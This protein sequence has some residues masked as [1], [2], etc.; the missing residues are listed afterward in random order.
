MKCCSMS[1][2][3]SHVHSVRCKNGITKHEVKLNNNYTV[4]LAVPQV[5][6]QMQ[7]MYPTNKLLQLNNA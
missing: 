2:L 6:H 3:I 4:L 7:T 5:K 1:I